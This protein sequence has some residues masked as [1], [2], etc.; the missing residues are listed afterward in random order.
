MLGLCLG[1]VRRNRGLSGH[2]RLG[3]EV[4]HGGDNSAMR[5]SQHVTRGELRSCNTLVVAF[6]QIVEDSSTTLRLRVSE[7]ATQTTQ[8]DVNMHARRGKP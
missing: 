2:P 1:T 8:R 4:V 7:Q 5:F 6:T 3:S